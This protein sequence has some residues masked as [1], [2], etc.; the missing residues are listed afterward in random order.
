M[1]A[2]KKPIT[3]TSMG[4]SVFL[5]PRYKLILAIKPPNTIIIKSSCMG[6]IPIILFNSFFKPNALH[7]G[8]LG[9]LFSE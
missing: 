3:E 2:V 8:I 1:N 6:L 5:L 7:M 9:A 4:V